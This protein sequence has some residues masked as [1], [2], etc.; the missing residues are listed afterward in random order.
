MTKPKVGVFNITGCCGCVLS[1]LFNEDEI[2]K[3]IKIVEINAFPFIKKKKDVEKFD[4]IFLE[5]T[6]VQKDDL[7]VLIEL[8]QKTDILVALG[9]C[10]CT[11]GVPSFRHFISDKNYQHL[12]FHK[13]LH[14][15]DLDP[16][17]IDAYVKV[18]YYLPG[19]PPDKKE[20]FTFFKEIVMGKKP[21]LYDKPV[22]MECRMN[23]NECL[24]DKG[25]LCLG[26]I[27]RGG[28]G[29]VCT[30]GRLECWGCRGPT[31][32]AN[33]EEMIK[34]LQEKGFDTEIIK[35]RMQTFV[36][37]KLPQEEVKD[38]GQGN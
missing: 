17:P 22:C 16:K 34:L 8:R 29:A 31:S 25:Q 38:Y 7:R 2:L 26:P 9:A 30:N 18:D 19:C 14:L 23:E 35:D 5:G 33:Y 20:I 11:G 4:I 21:R 15:K 6:V 1:I 27:T 28:C 3:L 37:L 10:A 36:G 32:D 12:V 24:L 13:A